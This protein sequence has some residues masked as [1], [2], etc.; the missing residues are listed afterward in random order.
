ML[1]WGFVIGVVFFFVFLLFLFPCLSVLF[2]PSSFL[3]SLVGFALAGSLATLKSG[4]KVVFLGKVHSAPVKTY[5][6]LGF[7]KVGVLVKSGKTF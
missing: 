1:L 5:S 2:F 3:L 7:C 4:I 6:D